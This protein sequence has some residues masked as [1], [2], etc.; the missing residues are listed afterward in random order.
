ME[1]IYRF[2]EKFSVRPYPLLFFSLFAPAVALINLIEKPRGG[3]LTQQTAYTPQQAYDLLTNYGDAGRRQHLLVSAYDLLLITLFVM[4]FSS[5][6]TFLYRRITGDRFKALRALC[7]VPLVYGA[8]QLL[9][10]IFTAIALFTFPGRNDFIF[11]LTNR[12]TE[13]KFFLTGACVVIL[14]AGF[15][16]LAAKNIARFF[17]DKKVQR[18]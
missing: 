18:E 14:L 10:V 11:I 16:G 3:Y 2:I 17:S 7:F 15:T 5:C 12:A 6:I 8:V 4:F 1:K 9:E 13:A